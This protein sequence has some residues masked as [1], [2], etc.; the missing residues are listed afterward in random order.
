MILNWVLIRHLNIPGGAN[1]KNP[2]PSAGDKIPSLIWEDPLE[3][4][5]GT[6][7]SLEN[8]MDRGAWWATVHRVAQ[9]Q[10]QLKWLNMQAC[11]H[12]YLA[13]PGL[14]CSVWDL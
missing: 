8:P 2:P 14:S 7:S 5:M 9:S 13:V 3:E 12:T 4:G 10:T 11:M 6:H 1:G